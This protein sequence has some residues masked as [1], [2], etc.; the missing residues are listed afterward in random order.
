M[1][2]GRRRAVPWTRRTVQAL[3]LALFVFL[4]GFSWFELSSVPWAVLVPD[5]AG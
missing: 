4:Y 1:R 2:T 3:F 5:R